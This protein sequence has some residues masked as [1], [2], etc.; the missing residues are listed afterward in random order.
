MAR[1]NTWP[2]AV[3]SPDAPVS[4]AKDLRKIQEELL[5]QKENL[6]QETA[7]MKQDVR[8]LL[9]PL[10]MIYPRVMAMP[11]IGTL[12]SRRA[13]GCLESPRCNDT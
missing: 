4:P 11:L 12:D 8:A 1:K 3:E 6:Q 13:Q 9:T 7:Q 2:M 10:I 5:E